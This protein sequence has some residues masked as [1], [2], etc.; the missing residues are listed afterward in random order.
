MTDKKNKEKNSKT[1][2]LAIRCLSGTGIIVLTL[3]LIYAGRPAFAGFVVILGSLSLYEWTRML[4]PLPRA[5]IYQL[6]TVLAALTIAVVTFS[7]SVTFMIWAGVLSTLFLMI[8]MHFRGFDEVISK[9]VIGFFYIVMSLSYLN[10]LVMYQGRMVPSAFGDMVFQ[11]FDLTVLKIIIAF[12][13]I[14]VWMSDSMAYVFGRFIGGPKL[15]PKIS[16][17]KTWA[18]LI[19]SMFGAALALIA[20]RQILISEYDLT[21]STMTATVCFGALLGVIGQ[22]GD[23]MVS[24]AKRRHNIKDMGRLIPGH[25]GVLD[26]IDALLLIIPFYV[27]TAFAIL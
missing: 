12:L 21:L 17:K 27:F 5:G 7:A 1:A 15:A 25:G 8:F 6:S 16:P 4:V 22:V 9:V 11:P 23:L 10:L 18:G 14:T 3:A 2:D 13:F 20:A 19:G 24:K 26:R